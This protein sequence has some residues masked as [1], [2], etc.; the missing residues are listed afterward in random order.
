MNTSSD[1]GSRN[2]NCQKTL[3]DTVGRCQLLHSGRFPL[4]GLIFWALI[5]VLEKTG[6]HWHLL[7]QL[8]INLQKLKIVQIHATIEFWSSK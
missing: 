3:Q 2:Q 1:H 7:K 5:Y 6:R 8:V 4:A